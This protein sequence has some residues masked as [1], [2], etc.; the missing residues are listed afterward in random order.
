MMRV[1]LAV[2]LLLLILVVVVVVVVSSAL[3]QKITYE[4]FLSAGSTSRPSCQQSE[5]ESESN[6]QSSFSIISMLLVS[7][8][9]K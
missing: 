3:F 5:S 7:R 9:N 4:T 6:N 2:V 1:V 8:S